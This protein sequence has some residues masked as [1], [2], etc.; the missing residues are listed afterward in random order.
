MVVTKHDDSAESGTHA[1]LDATRI[2][3]FGPARRAG[4]LVGFGALVIL[5]GTVALPGSAQPTT[6][7][8]PTTT[9]TAPPTTEETTTTAPTSTAAETTTTAPTTTIA[10]ETST[11]GPETTTTTV[12]T[13][14]PA[15]TAAAVDPADRQK[16]E[17]AES[18][19]AREVD[20]ANAQLSELTNALA[21]LQSD[22]ATQTAQV[23]IATRRLEAAEAVAAAASEDVAALEARVIELEYGLSDQAIR[24]F[25]GD[26]VEEG[27]LAIGRNPN[28]ALRMQGM[29][30]KATQ[31]DI[32]YVLALAGVREDLSARRADADEALALAEQSKQAS[33]EQL[34]AL[35]EDRL[36]QGRLA[37]GAE[38]RLDHLLS[39]RAAL[40]R[41]GA[42]IESG[43]D[44]AD[45]DALVAQL[46]NSPAPAPPSTSG[47]STPASS[48]T[49]ADIRLAGNGIEVHVDIVDNVRRLLADAAADGVL[50]A[51]GGYR[52]SAGQIAARRNNCGTSSY[53][54]YEMPSSRCRPPTARPGKSQHELGKAIDFTYNGALIR[55][56]SG[57]GWNWLN[58]NANEYGLYNLPSEPWHWSVNG[59]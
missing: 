31:S 59:R 34:L 54:I 56:R 12:G 4:T 20:A 36:A 23:E 14:Q 9:T 24:S 38:S 16:V 11:T 27:V 1:N 47:S 5:F 40:A 52:D 48:I 10:G 41:L 39:E 44:P 49:E 30:T 28:E 26:V 25:K 57:A 37:A 15:T 50:L 46:A 22:V 42:E 8:A 53:A 13:S 51:G 17:A 58:A 3:G 35:E 19:K 32:D 45:T 6:T 55:S 29:L 21:V 2:D 18:A 43:L 33:E 7:A